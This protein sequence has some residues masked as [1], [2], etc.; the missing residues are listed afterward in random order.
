MKNVIYLILDAF[1]YKNLEL[2][3]G[4]EEVTPFINKI[5]SQGVSFRK[6]YSQAPYTE[7]SQVTLLSGENCLDNGGYLFGNGNNR[8]AMFEEYKDKGY[9]TIFSY[10][11]YV[12]SKE[13]LRGVDDFFYSRVFNINPLLN[14][15]LEHYRQLYRDKKIKEIEWKVCEILLSEA[16][17]TWKIQCEL[18]LR[19][20]KSCSAILKMLPNENIIIETINIITGEQERINRTSRQYIENLFR[21]WDRHILKEQNIKYLKHPPY[22]LHDYVMDTYNNVLKTYQRRC[23]IEASKQ[24]IDMNYL[25]G[26]LWRELKGKEYFKGTL[27]NYVKHYIR[28]PIKDYL[29]D[30]DINEN[31][32][33]SMQVVFDAVKSTIEKYDSRNIPFFL[34]LHTSDFHLP[35]VFHTVETK[36]S[37]LVDEEFKDAIDLMDKLNGNY[38]GNILT[39]LSARFCD[40]KLENFYNYLKH[41]LKNDFLFIIT[42]DHGFPCYDNPPRPMIY[43]QTYTEAFHIPFIIYGNRIES[44]FDENAIWSNMD[45]VEMLKKFAYGKEIKLPERNYVLCEYAGPGCPILDAKPIWYTLIDH[46]FRVSAECMLDEKLEKSKL[47]DIYNLQIDTDEKRNLVKKSLDVERYINIINK[48]HEEISEKFGRDK[49]YAY[50]LRTLK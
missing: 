44:S 5:A 1:C 49:F 24:H 8:K 25:F 7:A 10:S 33:A 30:L 31:P 38:S 6:M 36:E 22:P 12:Y 48:R 37:S 14:Y 9:R 43:N 47:K 11:P 40:S 34:Y 29:T 26:M 18:A 3:I 46:N 42:A 20:D 28:K 41:H 2:K 39:A 32:E 16:L 23:T 17:D 45:A 4:E 13:Y 15:R 35:S 27:K 21:L 19:K 50:L